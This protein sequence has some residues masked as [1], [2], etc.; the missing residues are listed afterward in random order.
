MYVE[1]L[2]TKMKP[3]GEIWQQLTYTVHMEGGSLI[4]KPGAGVNLA[5]ADGFRDRLTRGVMPGA[6]WG[7]KRVFPGD[8]G[9]LEALPYEFSGSYVRARL[10]TEEGRT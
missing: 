10:V 7:M 8:D 6:R 9:F 4:V 3:S 5:A 2:S 1:I